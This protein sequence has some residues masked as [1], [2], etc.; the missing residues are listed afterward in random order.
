ME[1]VAKRKVGLNL[2]CIKIHPELVHFEE[3][4]FSPCIFPIPLLQYE[5]VIKEF[6]FQTEKEKK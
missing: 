1:I 3:N 5:N 4:I 2:F 6:N